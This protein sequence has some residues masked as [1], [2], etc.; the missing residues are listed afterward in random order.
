MRTVEKY[1]FYCGRPAQS[2]DHTPSKNL[3]EKP[4]PDNL[5][6][7]PACFKCN[8]SYS[9]DEEYFLNVLVEIS[10]NPTLLL[11]K[12]QGGSI[13]KA[14][15]RS[16]GLRKKIQDSFIQ[17]EDGLIYFKSDS[18][19]I[20]RVIEKNAFGLYFHKYKRLAKQNSF[21][22]VGFYPFNIQEK[23]PAELFML[24]YT[25]RFLPKKWTTIQSDV[26]SYIVVRN[27]TNN[28]LTMVFHIH[29]AVWCI[30]EIPYPHNKRKIKSDIGQKGLF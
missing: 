7:I 3:L 30:I 8:R 20:K 26:F 11:K 13:Y 22:C 2:K 15:K 16:A 9:K 28:K 23:R 5:L 14:R 21:N 10:T 25:E 24:G 4:Y 29:N 27:W 1:C 12:S 18:D 6:T 19:R 17:G